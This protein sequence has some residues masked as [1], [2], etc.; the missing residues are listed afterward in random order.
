[1]TEYEL[2]FIEQSHD[3]K[4]CFMVSEK[5]NLPFHPNKSDEIFVWGELY[6]IENIYIHLDDEIEFIIEL[7]AQINLDQGSEKRN[8]EE[9][10]EDKKEMIEHGWKSE[11]WYST[12]PKDSA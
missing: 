10:I 8:I 5:I 12:L 7:E 11:D 9:L 6:E 2:R 3:K 4:H 1:M